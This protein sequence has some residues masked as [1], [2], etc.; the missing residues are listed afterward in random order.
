MNVNDLMKL[1]QDYFIFLIPIITALTGIVK[2]VIPDKYRKAWTP[3]MSLIIGV[4][5]SLLVIGI[6]K[7]AAVIGVILGL[8]ACGLWSTAKS[9]LKAAKNKVSDMTNIGPGPMGFALIILTSMFLLSACAGGKA[10]KTT[11]TLLVMQHT[12]V[13]LAEA[14][15]DMC[16][17]GDLTQAECDKVADIYSKAKVSYD[18]AADMLVVALESSD[19]QNNWE[20]FALFHNKF[21]ALYQDMYTVAIEFKIIPELE[22]GAQ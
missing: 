13:S 3:V 14:A 18:L 16:T 8:S 6:T 20:A 4:G 11:D 22:G 7:I 15:D 12:I 1:V 5:S 10:Q 21:L 2:N 19:I 9:P 17:R